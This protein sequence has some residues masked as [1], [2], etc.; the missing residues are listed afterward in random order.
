MV[1]KT[2][3]FCNHCLSGIGGG[4]RYV[5]AKSRWLIQE[6]W[7][8]YVFH[9]E[10]G[11]VLLDF[12]D[13]KVINQ[14]ELVTSPRALGKRR[15]GKVIRSMLDELPK[16]SDEVFV[17]S[18]TTYLAFWGEAVARALRGKHLIFNLEECPETPTRDEAEFLLFKLAR[19]ELAS[20][21]GD[22][23]RR[24]LSDHAEPDA[25]FSKYK[26]VAFNESPFEDI[27]S[28][29]DFDKS[30]KIIGCIGRLEKPYVLK[31]AESVK[32]FCKAHSECSVLLVF[33]GDAADSHVRDK[34]ASYGDQLDNLAVRIQG[35]VSPIP[36][37]LVKSFDLVVGKSG[38]AS[39]CA[40]EDVPTAT[41]ALDEDICLGIIGYDVPGGVCAGTYPEVKLET[42][43]EDVLI[44]EKYLNLPAKYPLSR[45]SEPSYESHFEYG[46]DIEPCYYDVC[47]IRARPK[48]TLI[49]WW[50]TLFGNV[51]Y[52]QIKS[53]LK[54]R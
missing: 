53:I 43:L 18:A 40:R 31:M 42:V 15:F 48:R 50:L 33:V 3:I 24:L 7:S 41:Y 14:L 10:N 5:Q 26:L 13:V 9:V 52:G 1:N 32:E 37:Q 21:N 19:K 51:R 44:S 25:D 6:G 54:F 20:I 27:A 46:L 11:P 22:I 47:S 49:M 36:R 8:V 12:T 35:Y 17:E 29:Y 28:S 16:K 2:Y 34:I 45:L 23:L 4:Q 38:A 39:F 30:R